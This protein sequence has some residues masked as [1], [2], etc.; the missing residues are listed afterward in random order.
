MMNNVVLK[1]WLTMI[2]NLLE[3]PTFANPLENVFAHP[4]LRMAQRHSLQC[5]LYT[6][7]SNDR[8]VISWEY[9]ML[10]DNTML[11]EVFLSSSLL[12]R[13][14]LGIRFPPTLPLLTGKYTGSSHPQ[15]DDACSL[16]SPIELFLRLLQDHIS[17]QRHSDLQGCVAEKTG[18][19]IEG[20]SNAPTLAIG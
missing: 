9:F 12:L 2:F 7:M 20:P 11:F 1:P 13:S 17:Q 18:T 15:T 5:T 4:N 8:V 10:L 3:N 6:K 16:A 19:P 14:L